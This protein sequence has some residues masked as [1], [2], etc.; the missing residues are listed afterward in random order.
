[1]GI[2]CAAFGHADVLKAGRQSEAAI[3]RQKVCRLYRHAGG[4]GLALTKVRRVEEI[5]QRVLVGR[6]VCRDAQRI[7]RWALDHLQA[8]THFGLTVLV[9]DGGQLQQQAAIVKPKQAGAR[10]KMAHHR[11][12]LNQAVAAGQAWLQPLGQLNV[13]GTA[14]RHIQRARH[15]Q[16]VVLVVVLT[17]DLQR[18][19]LVGGNGLVALDADHARRIAA[20]ESA[21]SVC[22]IWIDDAQ[23]V[24]C[25]HHHITQAAHTLAHGQR[26][27]VHSH[28]I[29]RLIGSQ[30]HAALV[31][32]HHAFDGQ[33][34]G[35]IC[36]GHAQRHLPILQRT[37][38]CIGCNRQAIACNGQ[39]NVAT[40]G[41]DQTQ[42]AADAA[43][44]QAAAVGQTHAAG[45]RGRH[46][47]RA[48]VQRIGGQAALGHTATGQH[49]FTHRFAGADPDACAAQV[50]I[51]RGV[52]IRHRSG[53][54]G[55]AEQ[56]T[57][58]AH[59]A[60]GHASSRVQ[61]HALASQAGAHSLR[62]AA[63]HAVHA[64]GT[65]GA[66]RAAGALR[67][68]ATGVQTQA[69]GAADAARQSQVAARVHAGH[70]VLAAGRQ[71]GQRHRALGI[72]QNLAHA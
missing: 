60:Q 71:S 46:A 64:E 50:G 34:R 3:H 37:H 6:V 28:Q 49:V 4:V 27:A 15:L 41:A 57:A 16:L 62:D 1:M 10:T 40:I 43:H 45:R 21:R 7:G 26:R 38:L 69:A 9:D 18:Q 72:D 54:R 2:D 32:T 19:A 23:A 65:C 63:A 44:R 5:A 52:G 47:R 29:H 51:V 42:A 8:Q 67:Q 17:A 35:A 20:P 14:C 25:Y 22:A 36:M 68:L 31:G 53:T 11:A 66:D 61:R 13:D 12:G 70:G 33:H 58:C 55:Q 24:A 30:I 56:A 59:A 39:R 48:Q